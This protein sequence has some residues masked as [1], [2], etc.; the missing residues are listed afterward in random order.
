MCTCVCLTIS[1]HLSELQLPEQEPAQFSLQSHYL[2]VMCRFPSW[3]AVH[4]EWTIVKLT[5]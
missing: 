4:S 3:S 1:S 5:Q 2:V